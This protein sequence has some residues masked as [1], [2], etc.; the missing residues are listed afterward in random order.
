MMPAKNFFR[1]CMFAHKSLFAVD[2]KSFNFY[3]TDFCFISVCLI[4]NLPKYI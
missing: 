4:K 1:F 3:E 2:F